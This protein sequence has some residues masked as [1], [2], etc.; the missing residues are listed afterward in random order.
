MKQLLNNIK[1]REQYRP[2]AP[3]CLEEDAMNYFIPGSKDKFMLFEHVGTEYGLKAV[4]AVFHLDNTARLQTVC[5][6]DNWLL[7]EL[8]TEYKAITGESVLCNTSANAP[9]RG[10]FPDVESAQRWGGADAI[11]SEGFLYTK[12]LNV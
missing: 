1:H 12:I 9:G 7:Y 5:K 10:F 11:W 6:E 3:I 8:L 2:I 4:P